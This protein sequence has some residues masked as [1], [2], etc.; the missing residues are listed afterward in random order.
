MKKL[1]LFGSAIL[2]L[3]FV[4][5]DNSITKKERKSAGNLLK[6]TE[7]GVFIAVKGLSDAQLRFKP[8]PDKWSVEECLKHIAISEKMIRGMIDGAL[9]QPANPEKRSELKMTDEHS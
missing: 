9:K 1:L 5:S 7:T 3:S 8:A 6:D 4:A 2:L